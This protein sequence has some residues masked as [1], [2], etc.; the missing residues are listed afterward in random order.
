[1]QF[2]QNAELQ[3]TLV[4]RFVVTQRGTIDLDDALVTNDG[5]L[6]IWYADTEPGNFLSGTAASL[7]DNKGSF[8]M[9]GTTSGLEVSVRFSNTGRVIS[10]GVLSFTGP[11]DQLQASVLTGGTWEAFGQGRILFPAAITKIGAA[12]VVR[13]TAEAFPQLA[14]LV[15]VAGELNVNSIA[16]FPNLSTIS[17]SGRINFPDG[18]TLHA[19]TG[20]NV[21]GTLSILSGGL[22]GTE[23]VP[24]AFLITPLLTSNGRV[25][26]GDEDARSSTTSC[27]RSATSSRS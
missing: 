27:R 1:M 3:G 19:Q 18:T 24:E 12:A 20:L 17:G 16:S 10:K 23:S 6:G 8:S 25:I 7:F 11:V 4:N 26:P 15:E 5:A 22:V 14:G 9:T 2:L 13:G 21:G